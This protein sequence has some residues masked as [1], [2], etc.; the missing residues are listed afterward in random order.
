MRDI[1]DLA[2]IARTVPP[3]A[4]VNTSN[5]ASTLLA[6]FIDV[7]TS[8]ATGVPLPLATMVRVVRQHV[9]DASLRR[10][11]EDALADLRKRAPNNKR[12]AP[13]VQE[14]NRTIH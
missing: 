14:P 5:T 12:N 2:Q 7:G 4:A 6:G 11:I 8:G 1:R 9:K 3:E 10:R 13:P